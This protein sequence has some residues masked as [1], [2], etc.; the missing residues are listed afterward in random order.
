MSNYSAGAQG[1]RFPCSS[2]LLPLLIAAVITSVADI[3][4]PHRGLLTISQ[5]PLVD[6]QQA[7]Q[8]TQASGSGR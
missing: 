2:F 3:A 6:L 4:N 7:M 5:Q 8:P 1:A